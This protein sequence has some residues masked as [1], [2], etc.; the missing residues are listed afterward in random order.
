MSKVLDEI[1][2]Q[3]FFYPKLERHLV[4][5][6]YNLTDFV[7]LPTMGSTYCLFHDDRNKPSAK[8]FADDEDGI[9]KMYCFVCHRQYT[10]YD[11][12]KLILHQNPIQRLVNEIPEKELL[13]AIKDYISN[14]G[15]FEIRK[16][17]LN[18]D[19]K[20]MSEKDFIQYISIG[21]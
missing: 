6:Y 2:K 9:Q 4:E 18:K 14:A 7:D 16:S 3:R 12:I 1:N 10:A 5:M 15:K 21:E 8:F 11:Y 20:K 17:K 19:Y 13:D